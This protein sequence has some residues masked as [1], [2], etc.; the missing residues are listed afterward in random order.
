MYDH[1]I[2]RFIL[3]HNKYKPTEMISQNT[4]SS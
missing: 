4:K 1:W 2:R 3:F